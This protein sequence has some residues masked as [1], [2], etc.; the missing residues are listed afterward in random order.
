V[1]YAFTNA[2][3]ESYV[4][5]GAILARYGLYVHPAH[6]GPRRYLSGNNISYKR[7]VLLSLGENLEALLD[8]DFNLQQRLILSGQPLFVEGRALAAHQNYSSLSDECR[9]GRPYCRLLAARRSWAG[10]WRRPRQILYGLLTPL[11]APAIR[12]ARLAY[13]LGGRRSLWPGFIV[14]LPAIVI[15]YL[16]DAVGES[17]GYLLGV[18]NAEREVVRYELEVE[19]FRT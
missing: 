17:L 16:S 12:L 5:R 11:G 3:S 4:S 18:G 6:S 9:A 7:E 14:S 1:G 8:I 15:M 2:N 10:A 19:R 13:S